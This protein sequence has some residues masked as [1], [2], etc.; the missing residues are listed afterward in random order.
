[1]AFYRTPITGW[2]ARG[3]GYYE[4][5]STTFVYGILL[6]SQRLSTIKLSTIQWLTERLPFY[7]MLSFYTVPSLQFVIMFVSYC[8]SSR[9]MKW[10]PQLLPYSNLILC[11]HYLMA[12]DLPYYLHTEYRVATS[13]LGWQLKLNLAITRVDWFSSRLLL[14]L[15]SELVCYQ[16]CQ[17]GFLTLHDVVVHLASIT[18][19][20][21]KPKLVTP[22]NTVK[23]I[24]FI[25]STKCSSA[26]SYSAYDLR[27]MAGITDKANS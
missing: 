18:S 4:L 8:P 6:I 3:E 12:W 22:R 25:L 1:M 14:L 17:R 5:Q 9:S 20:F 24:G 21:L 27:T 19:V 26:V 16:E 13:R 15:P 2:V 23:Q 10:M 7:L 11:S